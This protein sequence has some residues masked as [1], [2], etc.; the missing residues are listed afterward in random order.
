MVCIEPTEVFALLSRD[1]NLAMGSSEHMAKIIK[2]IAAQRSFI[3]K[4]TN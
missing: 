1:F 4:H 3:T 2:H